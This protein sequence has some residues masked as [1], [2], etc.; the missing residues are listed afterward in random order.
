MLYGGRLEGGRLGLIEQYI[1]GMTG[2]FKTFYVRLTGMPDENKKN[3]S[4]LGYPYPPT[5]NET[6]AAPP[7]PRPGSLE[8]PLG[9]RS[10]HIALILVR[11]SLK[12][13]H[14]NFFP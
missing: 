7:A 3:S 8:P 9:V 1:H 10:T 11:N 5:Q 2:L 13:G 14:T 4:M 12:S 6:R